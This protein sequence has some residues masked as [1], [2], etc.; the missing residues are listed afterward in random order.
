MKAAV[1]HAV[2]EPMRVEE[3]RL[4][5]PRTGE[6]LVRVQAAGVCH[7]DLHYLNGDLTCRLPVVLGH[8]GAGIIEQTGAEVRGLEPGDAV[9]L[10]WRPR[11]G[12]CELCLTGRPALCS[13]I[14]VPAGCSTAPAGSACQTAARCITS[15]ACPASR[16]TAW[17]RRSP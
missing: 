4:A 7:S 2:G 3:T 17:S 9:V 1:L 15:S 5:E 6:V 14:K 10:M 8:E 12:R 16:S 11:C 13:A